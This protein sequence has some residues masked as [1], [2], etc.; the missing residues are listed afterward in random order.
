[1]TRDSFD[2]RR[3]PRSIVTAVANVPV[4][5]NKIATVYEDSS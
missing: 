5:A 4:W 2:R 1:M 3:A